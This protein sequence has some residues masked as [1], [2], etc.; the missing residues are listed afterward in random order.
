MWPT[1]GAA[2]WEMPTGPK[3][4][5]NKTN[6]MAL[7]WPGTPPLGRPCWAN[8]TGNAQGDDTF[9]IACIGLGPARG[10]ENHDILKQIN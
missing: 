9:T 6:V 4:N 10:W 1:T 8:K 5:E 3:L 7:K 2:K